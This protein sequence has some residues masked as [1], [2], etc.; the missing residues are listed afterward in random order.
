[1]EPHTA[2]VSTYIRNFAN[3][4]YGQLRHSN[5]NQLL[6]FLDVLLSVDITNVLGS[7]FMTVDMHR[8]AFMWLV[9]SRNK[10]FRVGQKNLFQKFVPGEE[11]PI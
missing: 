9:Y 3:T 1:M 2:F 4:V 11:G 10:F 8:F 7:H 6:S 5:G